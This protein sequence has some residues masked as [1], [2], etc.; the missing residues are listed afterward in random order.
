M[1]GTWRQAPKYQ[2]ETPAQAPKGHKSARFTGRDV[3]TSFGV[4]NN[5]KWQMSLKY[6][7]MQLYTVDRLHLLNVIYELIKNT[8]PT[9]LSQK[10]ANNSSLTQAYPGTPRD[11]SL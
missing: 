3:T 5:I 7:I 9:Y 6:V 4:K 2:A 10:M 11:T 1:G 8:K